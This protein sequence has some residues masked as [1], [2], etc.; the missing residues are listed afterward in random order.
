[1]DDDLRKL[2]EFIRLSK[3]TYALLMQNIA[4][5]LGIKF[6]FFILTLV[7]I[8]TMW[9]AVFAD[10]GTWSDCCR[11]RYENAS[12]ARLTAHRCTKGR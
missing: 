6:V 1:M 5:A 7:G 3:R 12:L 9:M 4:I 10:T 11:Q 8:G 2:P